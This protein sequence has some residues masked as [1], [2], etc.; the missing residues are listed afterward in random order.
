MLN[1]FQPRRYENNRVTRG[2]SGEFDFDPNP[3]VHMYLRGLYSS[4]T[5]TIQKNELYLQNLDG[6]AG[7]SVTSNG[8]N[9]FTATGANLDKFYENSL[10]QTGLGFLEAGSKFVLGDL[11]TV[12]LH[13]AY[14]EGFDKFTHNYVANFASND[15]NLTINY[16]TSNPAS[17]TYTIQT[18]N[19]LAYNPA[20]PN[21]FTFSNLTNQATTS[22]DQLYDNGISASV[23]TSFF[24]TIG[25]F[26]VGG[27]VRLRHRTYSQDNTTATPANGPFSLASVTGG[28][29]GQTDYSG[30]YSLG[31]NLNYNQFFSQAYSWTPNTQA[32]QLAYQSDQEN[33]YAGFFQENLQ[34]GRLGV[35]A[36]MRVEATDGSYS[37]YGSTTD[38]S[39]NKVVDSQLTTRNAD[40]A[41]VFP[42]LQLSYAITK[43][44]QARFAYS[45]GIARPGFQQISPATSLT[46]GGGQGGRDLVVTGNSNLKPQTGTGYD[47]VLA[48]YPGHDNVLEADM[49]LK[50]LDNFI[51]PFTTNTATTTYQTYGNINGAQ[52]RGIVLQAIEHFHFLPA[53]FDGL[54]I[55]ANATFVNATGNVIQGEGKSTLPETYPVTFNVT[56]TYDKG[57]VHFGLSQSYTGR[58]LFTVGSGPSTNVYTQPMF[59]LNVDLS[60]NLTP[61]LQLFFQGA[62]LTNTRLEFTQSASPEFPI[63]REY[64]AQTFLFGLHYHL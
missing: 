63:Q 4:N 57:K 30:L 39:G 60:Y 37:A 42:S 10:E 17:R 62:N 54:G 23:P 25:T 6:T 35:L 2:Y 15:Q 34:Y 40:Y 38:A 51:V 28:Q 61:H 47:L 9:N 31:P 58:N 43:D 18:A 29:G 48:Y 41:N 49:F 45:T 64:Y 26:E 19:G 24:D 53:P 33:V 12:D 22:I 11:V 36:G 32:D 56:E 21:N 55:N 13:S 52:A 1:T 20:N 3:Q 27:D 5:E 46:A 44:L 50:N 59:R 14:A 7:G 8:N 16:D